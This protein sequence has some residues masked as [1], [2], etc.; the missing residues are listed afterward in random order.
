MTLTE[1]VEYEAKTYIE[2]GR[3][4]EKQWRRIKRD[5]LIPAI[6]LILVAVTPAFLLLVL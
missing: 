6:G 2:Q 4:N 1:A 3:L 5:S